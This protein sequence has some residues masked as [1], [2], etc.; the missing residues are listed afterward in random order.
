MAC[1]DAQDVGHVAAG[2]GTHVGETVRAHQDI[3]PAVR[4]RVMRRDGG[5]CAVP[6]CRHGT[7]LDIHH[8][9]LRSE[10]ADHHEDGLIVLCGA[11][12][13]AQHR[14]QLVI[15]GRI[16]TGVTFQHADGSSYGMVVDPH[17]AEMHAEAFRALRGLG[18]REGE[19]RAAL[20]R[21]RS[22]SHVGDRSIPGVIREALRVLA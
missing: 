8:I 19:A 10:G 14:G 21:V 12:H 4:R 15:E 22:K 17:A 11:H 3:P 1:C 9:V 6:G 13:R 16:S 5:R 18:F 20:E 2:A 7:F